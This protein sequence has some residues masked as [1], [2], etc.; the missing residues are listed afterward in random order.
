[1][2]TIKIDG[3]LV[4]D[5]RPI[6]TFFLVLI[7]SPRRHTINVSKSN[8]PEFKKLQDRLRAIDYS[9]WPIDQQVDWR[10]V[11]AEMNGFDFNHSVLQPL[12]RDRVF[13]LTRERCA[14][15]R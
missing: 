8:T 6:F 15:K 5:S 7:Y 11:W 14:S 2:A 13:V 1:M 10:I 9:M 3:M 4:E 12:V